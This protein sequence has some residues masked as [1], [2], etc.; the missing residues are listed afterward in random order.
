MDISK[1]KIIELKISDIAFEGLGIAKIKIRD[2]DFV[3][4]AEN[5]APGDIIEAE[6]IKIKKNYAVA[7][8]TREIS[9]SEMRIEP[10]CKH[11]GPAPLFAPKSGAGCGGCTWQFLKYEDQLALK[12]K[13]VADAFERIGGIKNPPV[14]R[15]IGCQNPW[16]YRNKM[17]YTF[18]NNENG[19]VLGFHM[20]R[21]FLDVFDMEECYLESQMS[22]KIAQ[23]VK[24][25]AESHK[26]TAYDPQKKTGFLRNLIIREARTAG[27]RLVN[28]FTAFDDFPQCNDFCRGIKEAFPV[29]ISSL[30]WTSVKI[31]KG[32]RTKIQERCLQGKE[33]LTEILRV[34]FRTKENLLTLVFDIAPQAFF[35]PNTKQAEILYSAVLN[36][37]DPKPSDAIFDLFCGT[38]TIG[39]F[40]AKTVSKVYGIELNESAVFSARK[41]AEKNS[42]KNIDFLCGDAGR[43]M[44]EIKEKPDIIIIDPPRAG[45][46]KKAIEKILELK[47]P[48]IIYVSCNPST[49]SRDAKIFC[50]NSYEIERI[51]P[52]DMFPQTY[53]VET[54]CLFRKIPVD[55]Y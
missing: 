31:Q 15:I 12:Q 52:I 3:I 8:R 36:M 14:N 55:N 2:K 44:A 37:A 6:I 4:F 39:M 50:G 11:F 18:S 43:K 40:F 13:F 22:V 29:E 48:K 26:L 32:S 25:W 1:G 42:L 47:A 49:L 30:F 24:D 19:L 16:F 53:H 23:F 5:T 33:T 35:Q 10:R 9:A 27:E 28:L 20:R 38:G 17:E 41:N 21:R 34:P 51:Q 54:V 45:I 7:R 46:S